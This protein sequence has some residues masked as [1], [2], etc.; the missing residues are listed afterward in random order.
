MNF[1][2]KILH[3]II[4]NFVMIFF[5]PFA[6]VCALL[7]RLQ[8]KDLKNPRIVWGSTP[9]INNSYWS[10]AMVKAGYRSETYTY[11]YYS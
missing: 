2:K 6:A 4:L 9:I 11:D 3:K 10:R 5:I 1:I 7:A 8:Q